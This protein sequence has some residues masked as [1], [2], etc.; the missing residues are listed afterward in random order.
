MSFGRSEYSVQRAIL[1][2]DWLCADGDG[3]HFGLPSRTAS[4]RLVLSRR[5]DPSTMLDVQPLREEIIASIAAGPGAEELDSDEV[6]RLTARARHV[7]VVPSFQCNLNRD[8][9]RRR[10]NGQ[11]WN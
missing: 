4:A 6:A 1:L 9:H 8:Q 7:E 11:T 10:S 2:A 3:D 5:G